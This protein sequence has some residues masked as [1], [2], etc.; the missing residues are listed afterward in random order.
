MHRRI[1]ARWLTVATIAAAITLAA[2]S[3]GG[4]EAAPATPPETVI[5]ADDGTAALSVAAD[6]LPAGLT[7]DDIAVERIDA[8]ATS[9][10]PTTTLLAAYRLLPDGTEFA[11]PVT[12]ELSVELREG[13][14][15]VPLIFTGSTLEGFDSDSLAL[16]FD[17]DTGLTTISL[18]LDHFSDVILIE[19]GALI[20]VEIGTISDRAVGSTAPVEV[21]VTRGSYEW[22]RTEVLEYSD[23]ARGFMI[24]RATTVGGNEAGERWLFNGK[25]RATDPLTPSE[26][27]NPYRSFH[28]YS[29]S[30]VDVSESFTCNGTGDFL[31]GFTGTVG[32]H[33]A[34]STTTI[35]PDGSSFGPYESRIW[36]TQSAPVGGGASCVM[37]AIVASG[38]PP[39]TMYT[40][41]PEM[42]GGAMQYAWS[43]ADC[44]TA[45][46][47]TSKTYVWHHGSEECEHAGEAHPGTEISVLATRIPTGE[48]RTIELRCTYVSAAYGTGP[49]CT[50]TRTR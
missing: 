36:T 21:T 26:S 37:P 28:P 43:G 6:A 27:M 41:S 42:S 40:L 47:S 15:I 24:E 11:R 16:A 22:D 18:K 31:I 46:G 3:S 33:M 49:K 34:I 17:P 32:V 2:C 5:V 38:A 8:T 7:A 4:D 48:G 25:W 35:I 30:S 19:S 29:T 45:S 23:G 44:G 12:L 13:S 50:R 39:I 1:Q 14:S 10:S 9:G 20:E